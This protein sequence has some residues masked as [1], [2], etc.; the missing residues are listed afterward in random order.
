MPYGCGNE[1]C[2]SVGKIHATSPIIGTGKKISQPSGKERFLSQ[3]I[4][5]AQSDLFIRRF[6]AIDVTLFIVTLMPFIFAMV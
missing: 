4:V 1:S 5:R 3:I 2:E 6:F